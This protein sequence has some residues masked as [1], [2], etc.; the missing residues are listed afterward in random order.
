MKPKKLTKKEKELYKKFSTF[1]EK[2]IEIVDDRNV[3]RAEISEGLA[4]MKEFFLE[5]TKG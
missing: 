5:K 4:D 3:T 1:C 2:I